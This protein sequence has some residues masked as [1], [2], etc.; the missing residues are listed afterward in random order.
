MNSHDSEKRVIHIPEISFTIL[1]GSPMTL[2]SAPASVDTSTETCPEPRILLSP[3]Q[4]VIVGRAHGTPVPYLDAAY[5]ATTIV[6]GTQ[7]CVL[8]GNGSRSDH[9]VSRGH[10]MLRLAPGGV[11]VVN[12]VP[13]VDGGIRAPINGTWLI[14][15]EH[16]KMQP[17]EEYLIEYG[18]AVV[19]SLP[20]GSEVRIAA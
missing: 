1:S 10:F 4:P 13:N 12:G 17:A 18:K 20:N 9:S 11:L 5:E 7:Q 16:R 2:W 15:P 8:V 19:L 6:P 3:D 14:T